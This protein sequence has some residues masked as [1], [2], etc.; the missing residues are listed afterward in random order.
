[1]GGSHVDIVRDSG[2]FNRNIPCYGDQILADRSFTLQDEIAAGC[3]VELIMPSFTKDK[4]QLSS[5]EV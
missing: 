1:M 2:F 3:S 5:K 4:K